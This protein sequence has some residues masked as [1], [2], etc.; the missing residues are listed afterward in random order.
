[1]ADEMTA[2]E[3][4]EVDA[5]DARLKPRRQL[6]DTEMDITPMIDITF[7]LLIFFLVASK[8]DQSTAVDLPPAQYGIPVP[9]KNAVILTVDK[10]GGEGPAPV[11]KGDGVNSD[12]QIDS[13]DL[14]ALEK[15]IETYVAEI[16]LESTDKTF[17]L[18]KA[19]RGVKHRDVARV[20]QSVAKIAEIQRLHVAVLEGP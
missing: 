11:Y 19:A 17:V 15:E 18:I 6:E 3:P 10:G 2:V 16:V 9:T 7:L 1:M 12:N 8:M 5:H 4:N 13:S 14:E 20:A